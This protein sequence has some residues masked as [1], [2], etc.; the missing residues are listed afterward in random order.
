MDAFVM[1]VFR[2]YHNSPPGGGQSNDNVAL[3]HRF[4]A[5]PLSRE[6]PK[7]TKRTQLSH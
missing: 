4:A 3:T 1:I 7:I 6:K 5:N 2:E